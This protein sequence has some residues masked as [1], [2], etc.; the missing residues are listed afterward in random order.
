MKMK[1]I[2]INLLAIKAPTRK[3]PDPIIGTI[4]ETL[5]NLIKVS[6][7]GLEFVKDWL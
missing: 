5:L 3:I 1:K 6:R 2:G 7:I 4:A